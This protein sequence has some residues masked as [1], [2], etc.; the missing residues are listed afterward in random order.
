[1]MCQR[2]MREGKGLH[3]EGSVLED[4]DGCRW[5]CG[6]GMGGQLTGT[7]RAQQVPH[8]GGCFMLTLPLFP[9][10]DVAFCCC[11]RHG[12]MDSQLLPTSGISWSV[13][14]GVRES[15]PKLISLHTGRDAGRVSKYIPKSCSLAPAEGP[16]LGRAHTLDTTVKMK[17]IPW[18][19][20]KCS[21]AGPSCRWVPS[22]LQHCSSL[23][24]C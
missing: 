9:P 3:R 16:S 11:W 18:T 24:C 22:T 17:L 2:W 4:E 20:T 14:H 6:D 10:L 19:L 1:M 12:M 5:I 8:H 13:Q 21:A 15:E 7:Q 23:A